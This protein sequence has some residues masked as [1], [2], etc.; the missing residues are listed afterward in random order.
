MSRRTGSISTGAR[1]DL[2][3]TQEYSGNSPVPRNSK[4]KSR[5][6]AGVGNQVA[7]RRSE[8]KSLK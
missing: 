7:G 1:Q 2:P 5:I 4:E 3:R 6:K 8:L